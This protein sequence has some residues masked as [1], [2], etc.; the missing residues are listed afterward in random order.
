MRKL[1]LA[2]SGAWRVNGVRRAPLQGQDAVP[3]FSAADY[4]RPGLMLC[5]PRIK[6][7]RS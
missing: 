3:V 5:N 2:R 1:V 6:P 4:V 7:G